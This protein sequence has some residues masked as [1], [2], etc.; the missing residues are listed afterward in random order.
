MSKQSSSSSLGN[1]SAAASSSVP[2]LAETFGVPANIT[3]KSSSSFYHQNQQI[4]K[5]STSANS[6]QLPGGKESADGVATEDS[7][8]NKQEPFEGKFSL[9]SWLPWLLE[10]R[11]LSIISVLD[12]IEIISENFP[13]S[14]PS[15]GN[16]LSSMNIN[17][18]FQNSGDEALKAYLSKTYNNVQLAIAAKPQ[19][20]FIS[21]LSCIN[22]ILA[23][24]DYYSKMRR[25]KPYS[26]LK[27]REILVINDSDEDEKAD[28][29]LIDVDEDNA[30]DSATVD[31]QIIVI[32]DS[33]EEIHKPWI[34]PELIK[35]IKHRNL[36]QAKINEKN[37]NLELQAESSGTA[38]TSEAD[39][40]LM[41]KF[42]NL[43]NKVTKL[44]KKA[45][46]KWS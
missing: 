25:R 31:K 41:K 3:P 18:S 44:V 12:E 5:Y 27:M 38:T 17:A 20:N 24:H 15:N 40:E 30:T 23:D 21:N 36:L 2:E 28:Q 9:P 46:S 16:N 45:R 8:G 14:P 4:Q 22:Q 32:D 29:D 43:R 33:N 35:L 19:S 39:A 34:T 11:L 26:I 10:Q 1:S 42:K 37:K 6:I 13:I 7:Q